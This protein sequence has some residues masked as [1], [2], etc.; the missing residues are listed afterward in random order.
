MRS[1][2][3]LLAVLPLLAVPALTQQQPAPSPKQKLLITK[4]A[5]PKP[6]RDGVYAQ[7]P[8]IVS[9][10]LAHA[11]PALYPPNATKGD[12]PH[13]VTLSAV[14]GIDGTAKIRDEAVFPAGAIPLEGL[15]GTALRQSRFQPGMLDGRPVPVLVCIRV[16]FFQLIPATPMLVSCPVAAD[17]KHPGTLQPQQPDSYR[18]PRGAEA[19]VP[20]HTVPPESTDEARANKLQGIALVSMIVN[21]EGVPTDLRLVKGLGHGLD[22][23]ALDAAGQYRFRPAALKGKPIA[24]RITIEILFGPQ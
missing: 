24:V 2:R 3:W 6:D 1:A 11:V 5:L 20:I 8:G 17:I 19:P 16:M 12:T 7:G 10:N 18:L 22:K 13:L 21:E 14:I 9:P 4:A 23:D 15:A